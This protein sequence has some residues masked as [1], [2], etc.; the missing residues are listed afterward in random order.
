MQRS[1]KSYLFLFIAA[2]AVLL[3]GCD[4]SGS[5]APPATFENAALRFSYPAAW[6][7][8]QHE[9][10]AGISMIAVESAVNGGMIVQYFPA[11]LPMSLEDYSQDFAVAFGESVPVFDV[12]LQSSSDIVGEFGEVSLNGRRQVVTLG[13]FGIET[14]YRLD[15]YRHKIGND[16]V[17]L[18]FHYSEDSYFGGDGINVVRDSFEFL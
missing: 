4:G 13:L 17:F 5:D 6:D 1:P 16:A 18:I 10:S 7:L 14:G 9:F 12:N 15:F 8:Q 11:D 2:L 3:G